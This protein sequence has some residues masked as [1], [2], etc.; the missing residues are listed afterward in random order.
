M[1]DILEEDTDIYY[2]FG[3][4]IYN[5]FAVEITEITRPENIDMFKYI[6]GK[7]YYDALFN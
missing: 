5:Y 4:M 7:I 2:I 1:H 3:N 6:L